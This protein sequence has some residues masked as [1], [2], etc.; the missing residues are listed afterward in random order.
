M[1]GTDKTDM[2]RKDRDDGCA[3]TETRETLQDDLGA[4]YSYTLTVC[5]ELHDWRIFDANRR[6][7]YVWCLLCDEEFKLADWKFERELVVPRKLW[8]RL[9]GL[10]PEIRNYRRRGLGSRLLP[11]IVEHA[12]K[13]GARR[14]TGMISSEDLA[15]FPALVSWYGRFGFTFAPKAPGSAIVGEIELRL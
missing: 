3:E 5:D 12:R 11:L 13:S 7:G 4:A 8:A 2:H 10:S 1:I 6:I 9:L 14:I 15:E